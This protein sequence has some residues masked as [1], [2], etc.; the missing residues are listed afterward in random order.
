MKDQDTSLILLLGAP[1]SFGSPLNF[2]GRNFIPVNSSLPCSG[3]KKKSRLA[4][5]KFSQQSIIE[6]HGFLPL[7]A[8]CG[9]VLL[10]S[11]TWCKIWEIKIRG[12][13]PQFYPES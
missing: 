12:K 8:A 11:R 6:M 2:T 10:Y 7:L 1:Q 4:L 9:P 13:G 3:G 5:R